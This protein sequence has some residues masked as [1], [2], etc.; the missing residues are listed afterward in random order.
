[1]IKIVWNLNLKEAI[2]FKFICYTLKHTMG[3]PTTLSLSLCGTR[4]AST[5]PSPAPSFFFPHEAQPA[6]HGHHG[7]AHHHQLTRDPSPST[8]AADK[9]D[10]LV[11]F[12]LPLAARPRFSPASPLAPASRQGAVTVVPLPFPLSPFACAPASAPV[13]GRP[14]SLRSA[15]APRNRPRAL[16]F[17]RAPAARAANPSP[18]PAAS[19]CAPRGHGTDAGHR[20]PRRLGPRRNPRAAP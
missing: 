6:R 4:P 17:P 19:G 1:V 20:R 11:S 15:T 14:R 3:Q 8:R 16:H 7:P 13:T 18:A 10:P 2:K 9:R 12:P 5:R